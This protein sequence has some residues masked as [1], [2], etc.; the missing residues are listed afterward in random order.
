MS[1]LRLQDLPFHG[2]SHEFVGENYDAPVSIYFVEAPPG[3][4][5][6]LHTHPYVE[7]V[8]V[9]EGSGRLRIGNEERDVVAGDIAVVP[10]NTPHRFV[11]SGTT[12]LRQIDIHASP[13]FVQTNLEESL[14]EGRPRF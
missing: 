4:G 5:P 3:R 9:L 7:T 10:P 14:P 2:M 8:V 1:F 11:N 6:V 13:R 12:R